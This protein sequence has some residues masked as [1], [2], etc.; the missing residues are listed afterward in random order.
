[1]MI[2]LVSLLVTVQA[3]NYVLPA[4]IT[5]SWPPSPEHYSNVYLHFKNNAQ[6]PYYTPDT[7]PGI[8]YLMCLFFSIIILSSVISRLDYTPK[9]MDRIYVFD[10]HN[11]YFQPLPR[12]P[13]EEEEDEE[14]NPIPIYYIIP[15]IPANCE[16]PCT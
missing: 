3:N 15:F 5:G 9:L 8:S 10:E 4:S 14:D 2:L 13:E 12:I 11:V 7:T 16:D 1:M 6:T